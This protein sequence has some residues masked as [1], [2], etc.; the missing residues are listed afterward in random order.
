[1]ES[2]PLPILWLAV[3]LA[4][5]VAGCGNTPS[6]SDAS[7]A[8]ATASATPPT[9][10][11]SAAPA[12]PRDSG[13]ILTVLSV[14]HELDVVTEREGKV[15]QVERDE[16]S[17]VKAG[18]ELARL[19]DQASQ[20]ELQKATTD[21]EVAQSNVKWK[22]AE[23]KAKQ[24]AYRRQQLLRADG[25]SS[26]A[27]LETAEFEATAAS[28]SLDGWRSVVK[29]NELE[30]R[31]ARL[32]LDKLKIRAPFSGVVLHRY[33]REGQEISKGDKCFRVSQISPLRVQFLVP[34]G[35]PHRPRLGE[36]IL[37]SVAS[38][39]DSSYPARIIKL[40]P[41]VD[42]ASGSYDVVAQLDG[43][44]PSSLM[45]GMAARVAWPAGASAAAEK[46]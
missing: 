35:S 44:A 20:L 29:S 10:P 26:D 36:T 8:A 22:E 30:I 19:D 2:A 32:E 11:S 38:V 21:L 45:P 15:V 23:L 31:S 17:L 16:G 9:S 41:T 46:H 33:I 7:P 24:A 37:V 1:M 39:S 42:P 13:E 25:L 40:S 12:A 43:R 27:D 4:F 5:T 6:T 34:E 18:G 28:N 3:A 14:E